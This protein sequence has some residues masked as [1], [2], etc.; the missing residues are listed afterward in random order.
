M[1]K[2]KLVQL[3]IWVTMDIKTGYIWQQI[4]DTP[5]YLNQ[6]LNFPH[7]PLRL[8]SDPYWSSGMN[9]SKFGK[10]IEVFK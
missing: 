5:D 2:P 3:H 8:V 6:D 7:K 10:E 9:V 4:H 1:S